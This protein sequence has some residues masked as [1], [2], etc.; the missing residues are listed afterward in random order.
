[1]SRVD[2]PTAPRE[3]TR[4]FVELYR[5]TVTDVYSYLLSRV[6]DR[7]TAEDLTQDVFVAGAHDGGQAAVMQTV[8][9]PPQTLDADHVVVTWWPS[10]VIWSPDGRMLLYDA[11]TGLESKHCD[12]SAGCAGIVAVPADGNGPS[13]V[14]SGDLRVGGDLGPGVPSQIWG[15]QP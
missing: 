9:P 12:P 15:R 1:M 13:V 2:T 10:A 6:N 7:A 5:R 8:I 3:S 4:D 14:L 11:W